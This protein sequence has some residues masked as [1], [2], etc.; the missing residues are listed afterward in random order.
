MEAGEEKRRTRRTGAAGSASCELE[1]SRLTNYLTV[2]LRSITI[3]IRGDWSQQVCTQN[4]P[5]RQDFRAEQISQPTVPINTAPQLEDV[6]PQRGRNVVVG[7][8][9]MSRWQD[10]VLYIHTSYIVIDEVRH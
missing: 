7:M 6:Q 1:H 3:R 10:I 4:T 8:W 9:P 2:Q 5:G